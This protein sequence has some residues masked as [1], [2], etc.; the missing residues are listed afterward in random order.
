LLVADDLGPAV[1]AVAVLGRHDVVA[2]LLGGVLGVAGDGDPGPA[3][4]APRHLAVVDGH[5]VLAQDVVDGDHAFGE[6]DVGQGRRVDAV[7]DGPHAVLAGAAA[8]VDADE[9]ALIAGAMPP[10][11]AHTPP[12]R[13]RQRSSTTTTP[14]SSM[15]AAVPRGRGARVWARRPTD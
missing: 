14:R 3:V 6:P 9:P 1:G 4:D 15:A 2:G 12:S 13:V 11:P 5:R 7:A 8:L 10:P